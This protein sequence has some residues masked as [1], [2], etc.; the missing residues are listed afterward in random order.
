MHAGR[1]TRLLRD[2]ARDDSPPACP[3]ATPAEHLVWGFLAWECSHRRSAKAFERL[4]S[5]VVDLN[6][7]RVCLTDEIQALIGDRYPR[8]RKR[9]SRIRR[10]LHDL[11]RRELSVSIDHLLDAPAS[12]ASAYLMGL[13]GMLPY[14]ASFACLHGLSHPVIPIDDRLH[15]AL[16]EEG[17]ADTAASPDEIS[18]AIVERIEPEQ[19]AA[20]HLRLWSWVDDRDREAG[21]DAEE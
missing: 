9:A 3:A 12:D 20:V 13:D 8:S 17:I 15:A 4:R 6:E 16:I 18:E 5:R 10:A 1:L 19:C 7:L 14:A 21:L 2:T 11:H